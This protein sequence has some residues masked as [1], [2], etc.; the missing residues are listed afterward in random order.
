[1]RSLW[2]GLSRARSIGGSR[3]SLF[4]MAKQNFF[5]R[6]RD[7]DFDPF[8]Q[9][10]RFNQQLHRPNQRDERTRKSIRSLW[11]CEMKRAFVVLFGGVECLCGDNTYIARALARGVPKQ[12]DFGR[13]W[14]VLHRPTGRAAEF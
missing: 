13:F 2:N 5:A 12:A 10:A 1:M 8:G 3:R 7:G 6:G 14:R 4:G 11:Q 9:T